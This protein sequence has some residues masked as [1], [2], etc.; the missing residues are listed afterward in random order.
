MKPKGKTIEREREEGGYF[1]CCG[2]CGVVV[3]L[4][5]WDVREKKEASLLGLAKF[6]Y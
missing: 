5:P 3:V 2:G 6:I 1:G 4:C